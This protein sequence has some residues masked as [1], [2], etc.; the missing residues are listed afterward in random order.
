MTTLCHLTRGLAALAL[1]S[2]AA[3][4]ALHAA[5]SLDVRKPPVISGANPNTGP[6]ALDPFAKRGQWF[7]PNSGGAAFPLSH[8]FHDNANGQGG[9]AAGTRAIYGKTSAIVYA[10]GPGTAIVGFS[11]EATIR[12]DTTTAEG[13]W[14][15]GANSHGEKSNLLTP[16][17]GVLYR[18]ILV[19]EFALAA[20]I[21]FPAG[22]VAGTPYTPSSGPRI[23][24]ANH[25]LR[26]WYCFNNLAPGGNYYVPSWQFSSIDPGTTA[27][28]VLTFRVLD[29]GLVPA[30]PRYAA[31]VNSLSTGRDLLSNRTTSLKISNW[32][33]P[34]SIDS[35]AA[36]LPAG[37][38]SD[39]SVFHLIPGAL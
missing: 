28:R 26:A 15:P 31:L 27:S 29:G 1:M 24:A 33:E 13:A 36:Y 5:P 23:L 16:Y 17:R 22:P 8:E 21:L 34:L 4:V 32:V 14:Q 6:A 7:L 35:G 30:D 10:A 38:G 2:A 11:I 3:G 12:N 25:D 9:G 39:V 19:A 37:Q 18:P 20:P